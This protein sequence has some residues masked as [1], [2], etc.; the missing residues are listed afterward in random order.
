MKHIIDVLIEELKESYPFVLVGIGFIILFFVID[1]FGLKRQS[2]TGTV[3]E[4]VFVPAGT[5]GQVTIMLTFGQVATLPSEK[6]RYFVLLKESGKY[7][8]DAATYA[9]ISKN[10]TV[11]IHFN[12]TRL[13]RQQSF[14]F[15]ETSTH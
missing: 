4:L 3:Q 14:L 15:L 10:E 12:C 2:R 13:T 7:E 5:P 6:D 9:K 11:T 8:L 1:E